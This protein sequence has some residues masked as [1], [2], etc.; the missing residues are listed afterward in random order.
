M[1]LDEKM[2]KTTDEELINM[3]NEIESC[4]IPATSHSK[5]FCRSVNRLIEKGEM[6]INPNTYRRVYLPTLVKAVH[7]ELARRYVERVLVG[8]LEL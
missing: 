3:W 5:M 2:R 7:R 1:T 4:V 6:C 8:T